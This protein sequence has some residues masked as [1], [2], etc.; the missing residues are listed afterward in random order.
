ME[1]NKEKYDILL[2]RFALELSEVGISD[3]LILLI[4]DKFNTHA[5]TSV[6]S[7]EE[8]TDRF[9]YRHQGYSIKAIRT[10]KLSVQKVK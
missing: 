8:I 4:K 6:A 10:V 1:M 2:K 9:E 3:E 7:G 5:N